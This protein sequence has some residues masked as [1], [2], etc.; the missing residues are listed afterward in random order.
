MILIREEIMI[1]KHRNLLI[2]VCLVLIFMAACTRPI[3]KAPGA[4][5]TVPYTQAVQTVVAKLTSTLGSTPSS[6]IQPTAT[7]TLA[8][9]EPSVA[10]MTDTPVPATETPQSKPTTTIPGSPAATLNPNDP[11]AGLGNPDWHEGFG[12]TGSWYTFQDEFIRFQSV[13]NKLEMTTFEANKRNGWALA[14]KLVSNKFY[15]EMTA[16]FGNAC[17]GADHYG[18]MLSPESSADRGYLFGISCEG[19]YV[20]WKWDGTS[21]TTLVKWTA[22]KGI[23]DGANKTNRIGIKGEG[24]KISLYANGNLLTELNDKSYDRVYFGVFIG[25]SE[26]PNFK[27]QVNSINYWSLPD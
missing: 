16:T 17:K 7:A 13:G 2:I 19:K 20:L 3:G 9:T 10:M 1:L 26:T 22:S 14:P 21:M 24:N 23:Q 6:L 4:N 12:E 5:P 15:V 11:A 8:E 18:L 25:A 27:V